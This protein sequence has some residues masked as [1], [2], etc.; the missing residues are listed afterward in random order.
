[1]DNLYLPELSIQ[2][3][4][5]DIIDAINELQVEGK[6]ISNS[7]SSLIATTDLLKA[8][9]KTSE[10]IVAC[11]EIK[12]LTT[13]LDEISKQMMSKSNGITTSITHEII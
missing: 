12:K 13:S 11:D 6:K 1:M 3:M 7:V 5:K 10:G 4:E 2:L 9:W 8:G